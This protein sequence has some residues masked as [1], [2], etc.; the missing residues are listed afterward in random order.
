MTSTS[1]VPHTKNGV[2]CGSTSART[3]SHP[4]LLAPCNFLCGAAPGCAAPAR[5]LPREHT[6]EP[7]CIALL[8]SQELCTCIMKIANMHTGLFFKE[9]VC[10]PSVII[11]RFVLSIFP[12]ASNSTWPMYGL[13]NLSITYNKL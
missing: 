9:R 7:P 13:H 1:A 6:N 11:T 5:Q 4:T 10:N 12:H 8:F 3:P 2:C